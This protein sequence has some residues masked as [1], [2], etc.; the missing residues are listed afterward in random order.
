MEWF[1]NKDICHE[2][3]GNLSTYKP[4]EGEIYVDLIGRLTFDG[5]FIS[6][7]PSPNFI[8][9]NQQSSARFRFLKD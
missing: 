1:H 5:Q 3:G 9:L 7:G 8:V 4:F 6:N 2:W